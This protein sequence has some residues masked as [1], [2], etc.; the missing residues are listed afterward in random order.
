[1]IAFWLSTQYVLQQQKYWANPRTVKLQWNCWWAKSTQWATDYAVIQRRI[2]TKTIQAT[3]QK[4][5]WSTGWTKKIHHTKLGLTVHRTN[6]YNCQKI[7][8]KTAGW[9]QM[10]CTV[11]YRPDPCLLKLLITRHMLYNQEARNLQTVIL[12]CLIFA[13]KKK[14]RRLLLKMQIVDQFN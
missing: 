8:P 12:S 11:Y 2:G 5:R 4:K 3:S 13:L 1:M 14:D 7:N 9:I 6:I 10:C